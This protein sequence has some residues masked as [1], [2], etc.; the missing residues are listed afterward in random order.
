MPNDATVDDVKTAYMLS[1]QLGVKANAIY[2]DG[3]KLSQALYSSKSDEEKS[4]D[5]IEETN[6]VKHDPEFIANVLQ[7]GDQLKL[8]K[9]RQ[10]LTIETDIGGQKVFL[11]TG[12]YEDGKVGEIFI[13]MF[14]EGASFRSLLNALAV[15]VSLG[16]QYGVPLKKYVDKFTFTRFEPSGITNHEN[17]RTC[18][19]II[20]FVFR[21][22]GMEYLN[23][24]DFVHKKKKLN[25]DKIQTNQY[26]QQTPT[27]QETTQENSE[28]DAVSKHL[29]SMMGDAPPCSDCGHVTV[30][31]GTCYKCLNCGSSLG[32][33]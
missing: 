27:I 6:V 9:R 30:R 7:R 17:I 3:S 4:E 13:D 15:S 21:V 32:C 19:S 20:D 11:R 23:R 10:G 24:T 26:L 25:E 1:H 28:K 8:P 33:S 16:L 5:Q 31:N 29:E 2:R 12:E 14:K 22:L 18:T